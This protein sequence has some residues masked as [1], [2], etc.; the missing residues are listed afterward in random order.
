[1]TEQ[2]EMQNA[3]SPA[4]RIVGSDGWLAPRDNDSLKHNTNAVKFDQV[5]SL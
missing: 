4:H 3:D 1:M 2:S 5:N